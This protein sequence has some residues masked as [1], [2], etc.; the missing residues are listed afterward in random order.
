L[1]LSDIGKAV[2]LHQLST[3]KV[4]FYFYTYKAAIGMGEMMSHQSE[5]LGVA[6]GED[7]FL[8][9]KT[10]LRQ[11]PFTEGEEKMIDAMLDMY[12]TFSTTG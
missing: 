11:L 1:Y 10:E 4:F 7:I 6:H 5:N 12:E 2:Q 3:P 9:Y 8:F